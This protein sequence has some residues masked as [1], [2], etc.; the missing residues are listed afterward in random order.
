MCLIVADADQ[1]ADKRNATTTDNGRQ[2]AKADRTAIRG[3]N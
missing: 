1:K 3:S 2:A